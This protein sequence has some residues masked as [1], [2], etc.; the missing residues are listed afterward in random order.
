VTKAR[1]IA[2]FKFE[3]IV[4]T[5]TAGTK[6]ASGTTAQ[7][8]STA[9]QI[10]F[11]STTNVA[12][13]YDGSQ[14][15]IIETPPSIT[16]V[17]KTLIDSNSG[18]T[19]SINIIGSFFASGA[20]VVLIPNSGSNITPSSTTFNNSGSITIV[21]TDSDFV[22]ANE[23]Y[24]V[25][26]TNPSGTDTTL[27][28]AINVD[29]TVAW[30]TSAGSLGTLAHNATGNH[31]TLSAT[32]ADSDTITYSIQSGSL[33]PGLSLNTSTGVISGTITAPSSVTTSTFTVRATT[34]DATADRSFSITVNPPPVDIHF[35][36]VA[37]GGAGGHAQY[38][39]GG[40][41]GG[42]FRTSYGTSGRG[43]S[44]ES[45]L[46]APQGE[47]LTI[48][49]GAGAT[50]T[51]SDQAVQ[52]NGNNSSIT[53]SN[54]TDIISL[55]G[56]ASG[57]YRNSQ[58]QSGFQGTTSPSGGCGG[59]GSSSGAVQYIGGA[60]TT[61]QGYDGGTGVTQ[62]ASP[63]Y[64][65]GGGGGAGSAGANGTN[66]N[67]GNGGSGQSSSITGSSIT[68][69]GGGGGS[70][71]NGGSAGSG[72]SGGGGAGGV[73]AQATNGTNNLGGGGG[74]SE[75]N[76]SSGTN[77]G[78]GRVIIR[79]ATSD[80]TGTYTGSPNISTSGSDTILDFTG[81]GSYTA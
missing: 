11:N 8:G 61:G 78:S 75:R 65:A 36:V 73:S 69:S 48:T 54:I 42:G 6:V 19:S 30:S 5:G 53:N 79:V 72:G 17:S 76:G 58:K 2:D 45:V 4:D 22:N 37:G 32:D 60:G 62:N 23:P 13:Y 29:T 38:H 14:F 15:K 50:G 10:R 74:G 52:Q 20:T 25:K 68:F 55:G 77:G 49:V 31:Y 26:I 63:Y 27:D 71:Y 21:V 33:P 7:R 51:S 44:A 34:T 43:A 57:A 18:T 67:G 46:Q 64:G 81:T 12:E 41:G 39:G 3:N 59:G 47:Q 28:N 16:S 56:G 1:D 80:Y 66:Q 9:G 35:L 24:T 40:G 70:T